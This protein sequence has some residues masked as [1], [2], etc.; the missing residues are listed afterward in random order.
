MFCTTLFFENGDS[1]SLHKYFILH[2]KNIIRY[3][4]KLNNILI[5]Y[6]NILWK[7]KIQIKWYNFYNYTHN[8]K[9]LMASA[10]TICFDYLNNHPDHGQRAGLK[11]IKNSCNKSYQKIG[12]KGCQNYYVT[13]K[14]N[15]IVYYTIYLRFYNIFLLF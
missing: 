2:K 13:L 4:H 1:R 10:F 7:F 6:D 9:Y 3:I 15:V 8:N 12:C 11:N 14:K 5:Y